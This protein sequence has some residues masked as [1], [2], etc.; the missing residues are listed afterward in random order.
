RGVNSEDHPA[1]RAVANWVMQH[2]EEFATDDL[3]NDV[4]ARG[5]AG[6][7]L[8]FPLFGR[9]HRVGALIGFDRT[10]ASTKPK[11]SP[12]L[13]RAM[14]TLLEP[15]SMALDNALALKRAEALS[16]TDDLTHL[17]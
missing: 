9:G 17:Y 8:A 14:R 7:L 2:G 11:L 12:S 13:Q 1:M 3:R 4:R 6:A 5:D 15:V 10:P 16:V